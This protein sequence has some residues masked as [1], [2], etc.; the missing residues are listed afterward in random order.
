M[1]LE[2]EEIRKTK[3]NNKTKQNKKPPKTKHQILL[4]KLIL[5]KTGKLG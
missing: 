2:S 1:T 3:T 4:Q 5:N